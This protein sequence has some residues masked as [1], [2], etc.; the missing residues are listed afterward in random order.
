MKSLIKIKVLLPKERKP[1][2]KKA[3]VAFKSKK[4]YNRKRK[5]RKDWNE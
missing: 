5:H 3:N 1:I 2:A 4:D